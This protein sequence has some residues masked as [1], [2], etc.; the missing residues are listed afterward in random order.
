MFFMPWK[1]IEKRREYQREYYKRKA[2]RA[3][4]LIKERGNCCEDCGYNEEPQILQFHH[5][6][7]KEK[8]SSPARMWTSSDEKVR[9]ESEKCDILCP[10]CHAIRHLK[11]KINSL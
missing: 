10:N 3:D 4:K 7:P 11:M 5:R 6:E 1:D 9:K 2:T 8:E